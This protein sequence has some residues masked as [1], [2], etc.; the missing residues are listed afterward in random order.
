MEIP[1]GCAEI[2]MTREFLNRS[3]CSAP[4]SQV[5]TEGVPQNVRSVISQI[6]F[7]CRPTDEGLDQRLGQW[8]ALVALQNSRPAEMSSVT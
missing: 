7:T 1:L 6:R 4:H 3:G 2:L 5:R 8:T